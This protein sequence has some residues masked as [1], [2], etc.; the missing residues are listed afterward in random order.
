MFKAGPKSLKQR[1]V[2]E[3]LS[4]KKKCVCARIRSLRWGKTLPLL[5]A[6]L[7]LCEELESSKVTFS[8]EEVF[9]IPSSLCGDKTPTPDGFTMAFWQHYLNFVKNEVR[10]LWGVLWIRIIWKKFKCHI[11][12]FAKMLTNR[13]KRVV[14]RYPIINMPL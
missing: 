4:G 3:C 13:L 8:K 2:W 7:E 6:L 12:S 11:P 9:F 10:L 1:G 14:G 5:A